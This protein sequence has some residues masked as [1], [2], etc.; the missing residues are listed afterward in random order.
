[1]R[2]FR[3]GQITGRLAADELGISRQRFYKL[4]KSF[5]AALGKRSSH[6]WTPGKSGGNHRLSW[7]E[8]ARLLVEKLLKTYTPYSAVASE[9]LR[10]FGLKTNRATVRRFALAHHLAPPKP[11]VKRR[12]IRRWQTQKIGQLWQYDASPHHWLPDKDWQ[13]SL[14]NL[15]DDHSRL[16]LAA[17]L[18]P[19][20]T[21]LAHFEFLANAFQLHGLP[22][23]VYVDYHSFFFSQT[24]E[25]HT[26][27]GAA[28]HFYEVT[29]RFAPTAQAKGKIERSHQVWQKRLPP[30]FKAEAIDTLDQAN[31]LLD[32]LRIHRNELESHREINSTPK[33]AWDLAKKENRSALRL[34]PKCPWWPYVFSQKTRLRV[35]DDGKVLIGQQRFSIDAPPRS[36]V[37]R[38]LHP[39]GDITVLKEPP[40]KN[41]M[42]IILLSNRL[43]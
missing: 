32:Q 1:M 4:Y 23:E 35:G 5:L 17:R 3:S 15:L 36:K 34:A 20:E 18:Y 39:N 22:L 26:Q 29:F 43:C 41:H 11:P 27:L 9:V 40:A 24:P 42:P 13:P 28:L 14:L 31:T 37:I 21:L 8:N 6:S 7:P 30:I 33:A 38:C 16:N 10:R 12:P 2:R 19:H 25:A